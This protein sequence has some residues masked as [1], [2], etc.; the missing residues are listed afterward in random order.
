MDDNDNDKFGQDLVVIGQ[1][2]MIDGTPFQMVDQKTFCVK[3]TQQGKCE[4]KCVK[5]VFRGNGR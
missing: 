2:E 3:P 5:Q 1:N 4:R